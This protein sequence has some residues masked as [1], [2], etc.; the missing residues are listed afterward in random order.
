MVTSLVLIFF[1]GKW[2]A[3]ISWV[4]AG[5]YVSLANFCS[6]VWW[7]VSTICKACD[8]LK[9]AHA[10]SFLCLC[11][12]H[13]GLWENLVRR[14]FL[15]R[16]SFVG[17]EYVNTKNGNILEFIHVEEKG[18]SRIQK[19]RAILL[20]MSKD[21]EFLKKSVFDIVFRRAWIILMA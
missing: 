4:L 6:R 19:V 21:S 5:V 12:N 20:I 11:H 7:A 10:L 17:W 3:K 2:L 15:K 18:K 9:T 14:I 1:E 16:P 8:W 13:Y